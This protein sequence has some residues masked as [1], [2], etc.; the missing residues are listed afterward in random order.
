ML[1]PRHAARRAGRRGHPLARQGRG[2][3][4]HDD[5]ECARCISAKP[6]PG[7]RNRSRRWQLSR[8]PSQPCPRLRPRPR[9]P[10]APLPSQRSRPTQEQA[11]RD[12]AR[13]TP[14][15]VRAGRPRRPLP[16]SRP[17]PPPPP[18]PPCPPTAPPGRAC[19]P[20]RVHQPGQRR[21]R[22]GGGVGNTPCP[23]RTRARSVTAIRAA[24]RM[25]PRGEPARGRPCPRALV[26]GVY[27]RGA[28]T[29]ARI[30]EP[31]T[32]AVSR[33]CRMGVAPR[34]NP[35]DKRPGARP[36]GGRLSMAGAA[37]DHGPRPAA[38]SWPPPAPNTE[39]TAPRPALSSPRSVPCCAARRT[40]PPAAGSRR[41][42]GNE[43]AAGKGKRR[44][45]LQMPGDA[46]GQ[47]ATVD[48]RR[49]RQCAR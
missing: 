31:A 23:V 37:P 18:H 39:I 24:I 33:P 19:R 3:V 44:W 21:A 2:A 22:R 38:L 10:D 8:W 32:R 20:A 4:A 34:V 17:G 15:P 40:S 43:R 25:P 13:R 41:P 35:R 46:R 6:R 1:P 26:P 12:L 7:S 5:G 49:A 45:D 48:S 27:P 36:T 9:R 29:G 30:Q 47:Y 42:L 11:L 14:C 28:H 16:P